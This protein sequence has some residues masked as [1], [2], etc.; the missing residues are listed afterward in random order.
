[1]QLLILLKNIFEHVEYQKF[2]LVHLFIYIDFLFW[3]QQ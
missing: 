2:E 3:I 1:M